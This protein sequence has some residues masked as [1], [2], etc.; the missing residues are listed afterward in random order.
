VTDY[1]GL[2][3]GAL[4]ILVTALAPGGIAGL[5]VRLVRGPGAEESPWDR[6]APPGEHG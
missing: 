2:V 1:S 4:L 5:A 3:L 6:P